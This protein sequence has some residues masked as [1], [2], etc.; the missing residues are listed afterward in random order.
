MAKS[1]LAG[2][3]DGIRNS[4][5]GRALLG[6]AFKNANT[7]ST[8]HSAFDQFRSAVYTEDFSKAAQLLTSF[9]IKVDAVDP[10]TGE[11]LLFEIARHGSAKGVKFL[12]DNGASV[13]AMADDG[14]TPLM[15]GCRNI[16]EAAKIIDVL[17]EAGASRAAKDREGRDVLM[18]AMAGS[19]LKACTHLMT[20]YNETPDFRHPAV[21][22]ALGVA[23]YEC[24]FDF[25]RALAYKQKSA[26][27][28]AAAAKPAA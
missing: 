5:L 22:T 12:T 23:T 20:K 26:S 28:A 25:N 18:N 11:T 9:P 8:T 2:F 3:V 4:G 24:E 15:A 17:C 16:D 13:H 21:E 10:E 6:N 1:F 19:C 7:L 14:T 27:A